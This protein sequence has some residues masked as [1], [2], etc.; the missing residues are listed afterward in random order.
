MIIEGFPVLTTND[1]NSTTYGITLRFLLWADMWVLY[2]YLATSFV[3]LGISSR[4]IIWACHPPYGISG[5]RVVVMARVDGCGQLRMSLVEIMWL[6]AMVWH[7]CL[8][9]DW[10]RSD[11]MLEDMCV[12]IQKHNKD[13][14]AHGH[15]SL[16]V[17]PR[18]FRFLWAPAFRETRPFASQASARY[19]PQRCLE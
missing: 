17:R 10:E 12:E 19:S 13:S 16:P 4:D 5:E 6:T 3:A 8:E 7:C 11:H 9:G 18:W 14:R 1:L 2:G 15:E